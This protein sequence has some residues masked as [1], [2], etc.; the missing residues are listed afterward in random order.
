[1]NLLQIRKI[2]KSLPPEEVQ[3]IIDC[4]SP[5]QLTEIA[6]QYGIILNEKDAKTAFDFIKSGK[7]KNFI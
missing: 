1:M 5:A 3:R 2:I 7:Y 4:T 6:K